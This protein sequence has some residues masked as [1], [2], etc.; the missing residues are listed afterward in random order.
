MNIH[1]PG[2]KGLDMPVVWLFPNLVVCFGCGL[3]LFPI[4][5]AELRLL[6]NGVAA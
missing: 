3:T 5:D 1:F 4:P 6:E 2:R